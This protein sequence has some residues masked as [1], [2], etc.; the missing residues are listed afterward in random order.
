MIKHIIWDFDGT[1]FDTYPAIRR[2]FQQ[3]LAEMGH[4]MPQSMFDP[5]I[6]VNMDYCIKNISALFHVDPESYLAGFRLKY[7]RIKAEESPPF[8]GVLEICQAV[9]D[10]GGQN[11]I[12]THRSRV[13]GERLLEFHQMVNLFTD[14]IFR[15]DGFPLKPDPAM[16][17][18]LIQKYGLNKNETLAIGDRALDIAAGKAAGIQTALFLGLDSDL[19]Q[20]GQV[21]PVFPGWQPA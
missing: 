4:D 7:E 18:H 9:I 21:I 3:A 13:T 11:F 15:D 8:P 16:F 1:L 5:L 12:V 10:S 2:A 17:D 6:K 20:A 14:A 19:L